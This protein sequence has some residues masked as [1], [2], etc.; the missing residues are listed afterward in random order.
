LTSDRIHLSRRKK[1]EG[2]RKKEEG[3]RKKDYLLALHQFQGLV[4]L[5]EVHTFSIVN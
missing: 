5:G 4:K 2:R 1:E 3:R